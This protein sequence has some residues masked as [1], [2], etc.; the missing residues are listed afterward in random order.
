MTERTFCAEFTLKMFYTIMGWD[1]FL[2]RGSWLVL[3][4][5]I[6]KQHAVASFNAVMLSFIYCLFGQD[7]VSGMN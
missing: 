3:K 7:A 6:T 4:V 5:K 2:V 1:Y